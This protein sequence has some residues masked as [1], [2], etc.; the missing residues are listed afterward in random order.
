MLTCEPSAEERARHNLTH[1]PPR[2]WCRYCAEGKSNDAAHS[3]GGA[4]TGLPLI[5]FDYF[6]L[7][8]KDA[9]AQRV[10]ITIADARTAALVASGLPSKAQGVFLVE[11]LDDRICLGLERRMSADD[12]DAYQPQPKTL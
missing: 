12:I 7:R 5:E 3:R 2:P 9:D 8:K 1:L 4:P 10:G 6:F 11:L